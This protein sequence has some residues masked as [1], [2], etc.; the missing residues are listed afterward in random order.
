MFQPGIRA[1][2]R[3]CHSPNQANAPVS[4][5][6]IMAGNAAPSCASIIA[7]DKLVSWQGAVELASLQIFSAA[8]FPDT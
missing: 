1:A 7:R 5:I 6:I 4:S 2:R 3:N 8:A